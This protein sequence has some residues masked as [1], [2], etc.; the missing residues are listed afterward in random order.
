MEIL[1]NAHRAGF[2]QGSTGCHVAG[3]PQAHA[4][5]GGAHGHLVGALQCPSLGPAS[6]ACLSWKA[7]GPS[8]AH[9]SGQGAALHSPP[10]E[11]NGEWLINMS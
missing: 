3:G 2:A 5:W 6:H 9:L 10:A 4:C 8:R 7:P 11:Q 1:I